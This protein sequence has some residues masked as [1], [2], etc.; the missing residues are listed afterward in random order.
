MLTKRDPEP[1]SVPPSTTPTPTPDL[2]WPPPQNNL[3]SKRGREWG[4]V[5]WLDVILFLLVRVGV[6]PLCVDDGCV[7]V[8]CIVCSFGF[9]CE[10]GTW[11]GGDEGQRHGRDNIWL[12]GWY[13]SKMRLYI[14]LSLIMQIPLHVAIFTNRASCN[15]LIICNFPSFSYEIGIWKS[16]FSNDLECGEEHDAQFQINLVQNK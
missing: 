10:V 5:F 1:T 8:R 15:I 11:G 3:V 12:H 2:L 13:K 14:S 4:V 6:A 7:C 9:V 16:G